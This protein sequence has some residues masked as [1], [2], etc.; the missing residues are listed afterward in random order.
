LPRNHSLLRIFWIHGDG[1]LIEI[2]GRR[3][4]SRYVGLRRWKQLLRQHAA[5]A[6]NKQQN[7]DFHKFKIA[8][9]SK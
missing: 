3:R 5:G 9:H 6:D 7:W 8:T 2:S 4:Y 1:R